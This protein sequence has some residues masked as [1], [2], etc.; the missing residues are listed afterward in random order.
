MGTGEPLLELRDV[1]KTFRL[2][3]AERGL[4]VLQEINLQVGH[5]ESL[6]IMGASGSGKSTL[7]QIA[8]A[9]DKPT[10]GEVRLAGRGLAGLSE[11]D[12]AA[13]RNREIGFVFQAHYLLPQCTVF[14]NVL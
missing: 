1:S 3:E 6:A 10:S 11:N 8:G 5:S 13:V 4:Q 7:L 14:E 12:L 2:A 9:L